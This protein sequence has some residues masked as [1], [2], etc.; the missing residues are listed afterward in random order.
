MNWKKVVA[1]T[2][3][4]ALSLSLAVPAMAAEKP[5]DW[6]PADGARVEGPWYAEAVD[7]VTEKGYMVGTD[8]G[9]EPEGIVTAAQIFQTLYNREGKVT[10]TQQPW[11]ADATAW[12]DEAGFQTST[13]VDL[14]AEISRVAI[15]RI[16]T[17][18][19]ETLKA[20]PA[21]GTTEPT[22]LADY[23]SINKTDFHDVYYC[24]N[25]GLMTGNENG[26]WQPNKILTR[27]EFAQILM[28]LDG[29]VPGVETKRIRILSTSDL[30]GWFVP[31][32]F[33]MDKESRVGGMTLLSPMIAAHRAE[34]PNTILVDAGDTVQANYSEYFIDAE[35]NP[36]IEAM[37]YLGYDIW[38]WGN[39]EY[40]FTADRRQ[41]LIDNFEGVTLSGNVYYKGTDNAYLPATTVIEKDGVKVGFIGMCTPMIASFEAGRGTLDDMDV[42]N[43]LDETQKALDELKE[44]GADVIVG[45]YHMGLNQENK[46]EGTSVTEIAEKY[47]EIDVILAGHAHKDVSSVNTNGVLITEPR[48][49]ARLL[50]VVDIDVVAN[51]E[52]GYSVLRKSAKTEGVGEAEDQAMV[53]LMAPY[54]AELQGYVNTAIGELTNSDLSK[55]DKIKGISS[56]FTEQ[57]GIM[58]LFEL[59]G[60]YYTKAD[61][62]SLNTDYEDAGFPVGPI[63]IKNI[64]QS[65]SYSGGEVTVYKLTGA[66]VKL[67]LEWCAGYYNQMEEGDLTISYDPK[68]REG[69]ISEADNAA[70]VTYWIDLTKPAGERIQDLRLITE[71]D[72]QGLPVLDKDG[73]PTTKPITD[74]MEILFGCNSYDMDKVRAPGGLLEGHEFETV[75]NSVS[76]WG[77]DGT[78]RALAIR[79][80][81]EVLEGKVDGDRFNYQGWYISTGV[82]ETSPE[83]LK[84]VELINNGTLVPKALENG[85]TNVDSITVED[86]AAY[87]GQ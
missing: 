82:D 48:A 5:A 2:L 67:F 24:L 65:Y 6:T 52:G 84:A 10:K 64:S 8:N 40:N 58:T 17:W 41:K 79:Y 42:R 85:R 57:T 61:V 15:A 12:M 62:V 31:W 80:I 51:D 25:T 14:E 35:K 56:V 50:S 28:R 87:L 23:S 69:S 34:E 55:E 36:M 46:V 20:A 59:A 3:S 27:A 11:Y 49:Y 43:P 9:F 83:Y 16:L 45:V 54:K 29:V 86:V 39:H 78:V 73:K 74:D 81:T 63:S 47:P 70:G 7:Y 38:A 66:E 44:Q 13:I 18:Y 68:R 32:D 37:N 72:E 75:F 77:D 4:T 76:E 53:E 71:Y 26:E 21:E 33:A 22:T 60:R 30:H 19:G 1:L